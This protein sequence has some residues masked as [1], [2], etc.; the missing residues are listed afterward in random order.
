MDTILTLYGRRDCHLCDEMRAALEHWRTRLGFVLALKDID[1]D[2][3]L[4]ARFGN[5]I[6]VLMHDDREICRVGQP[7]CEACQ[8]LHACR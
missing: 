1:E 3:E 5:K 4:V 7:R 8:P 6:P 2:P